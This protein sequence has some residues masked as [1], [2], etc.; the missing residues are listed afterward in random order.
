MT[1]ATAP[2]APVALG[3]RF[4]G[5]KYVQLVLLLGALTAIGPLTIDTYLPAL[6]ALRA[7]LQAGD[8]STQLTMTGLLAGL[9][10]GQ[11][12][13]GPLS[14]SVGRRKPLI[15]GLLG[16]ALMSLV[17][18]LAPSIEML[19]IA[20]TVQGLSGAA[21]AVVAM[22]IVRD[23]FTGLKAAQLLSRLVLVTG[24]SPILA[25]SLGS[26]LL[27]L[28]DWQGIFVVLALIALAAMIIAVV[29]LPETLPTG[30]R[31][32]AEPL[33]WL[34][35]YAGLFADRR[36]LTM[37]AVAALMFAA[38]FGY[39]AGSPF[40]LQDVFGLS[41]ATYGVVFAVNA[42]GLIV[43][44]QLNPLLVKRFGPERV[45]R[46]A[47]ITAVTASVALLLTS[48]SGAGLIGFVVP[49]FA[50]LAACGVS[51]PN[52]AAIALSRHGEN[53]GTAAALLGSAQ[54][55]IGGLATPLVGLLNNG[56]AV[57]LAGMMILATGLAL[58]LMLRLSRRSL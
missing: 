49:I 43:M 41:P 23:L 12:I 48:L 14:D 35:G 11:L 47:V 31:V 4:V 17:C 3:D 38:L 8:A 7:E 53:A 51:A 54:F 2:S 40:V 37:V 10:L 50:L 34:Q 27:A 29:A 6:P 9:G 36:Y 45:L 5:R 32:P 33:R 52:A 55:V 42:V 20:R 30:R 19:I 18:A 44:T 15:F 13:I 26:A 39:V 46:G 1:S 22:A 16:H 56:T 58:A 28:T 24:V 57:P 25:P 21:V